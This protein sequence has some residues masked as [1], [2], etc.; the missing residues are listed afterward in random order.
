MPTWTCTKCG[1][2][3][4]ENFARCQTPICGAVQPEFQSYERLIVPET[5]RCAFSGAP[6]DVQLPNGH[7]I[8][9]PYLLY[10]TK[11]GWLDT[12]LAFTESFYQKHPK[13]Q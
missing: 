4:S 12:E 2:A 1:G 11:C 7:A 8:W 3:N 5:L 10:F 9:P 6:T 13:L